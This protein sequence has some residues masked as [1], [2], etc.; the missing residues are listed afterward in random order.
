MQ[1]Q[2]RVVILGGGVVGAK[3]A[4]VICDQPIPHKGSIVGW[5]TSGG[6]A[7]GAGKST[8]QGYLPEYIANDNS[9]RSIE[10]RGRN[11][12]AKRQKF[13]LFD[14]DARRMRS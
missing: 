14:L 13:L 5:V 12:N 9:G 7:Q 2:F 3:D 6:H 1:D 10:L 8:A 11:L 4:D